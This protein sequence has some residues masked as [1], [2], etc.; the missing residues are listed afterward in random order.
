MT[1][2]PTDYFLANMLLRNNCEQR[3]VHLVFVYGTLKPGYSNNYL[4]KDAEHV[5]K[6]TTVEKYALYKQG[7]PY[8]TK[9]ES[10]VQIQGD[11]YLVDDSTLSRLDQ[12]EGHPSWYCREQV[13]VTLATGQIVSAWIYFH[14]NPEGQII[15]SG[16]Y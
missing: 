8:V 6:G 1:F 11:V 7:I 15:H 10:I 3:D 12:L 16:C 4:L 5:D 13:E 14:P 9:N 2:S